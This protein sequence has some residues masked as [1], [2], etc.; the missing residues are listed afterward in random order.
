M[1]KYLL[2]SNNTVKDKFRENSGGGGESVLETISRRSRWNFHSSWRSN[3]EHLAAREHG[4][5]EAWAACGWECPA[6]LWLCDVRKI[7]QSKKDDMMNRHMI[8]YDLNY[9]AILRKSEKKFL[10]EVGIKPWTF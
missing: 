7:S 2:S 1:E 10:L 4:Y 3:E 5:F 8:T 6:S 9:F